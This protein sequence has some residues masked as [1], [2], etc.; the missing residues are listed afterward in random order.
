MVVKNIQNNT[1]ASTA[2]LASIVFP[3]VATCSGMAAAN[4]PLTIAGPQIRYNIP[5][6]SVCSVSETLPPPPTAGCTGGTVPT[7]VT[8]PTYSPTSATVASGTGA[9]ITITNILN[10][11]TPGHKANIVT[12]NCLPPKVASTDGKVCICPAGRVERRGKCVELPSCVSPATLNKTGTGCN[13]PQGMQF[14]GRTCV[15]RERQKEL[16][17]RGVTPGDVI[18]VIPG[19]GFPGMG[20]GGGVRG[21]G[22]GGGAGGAVR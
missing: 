7:W 22:G 19:I 8:P 13:C 14:K 12:L 10:C 11:E 2:S 5:I 15:E 21:G 20:G 1:S 16:K 6:G 18:R 17:Q 3:T 4:L 9:T